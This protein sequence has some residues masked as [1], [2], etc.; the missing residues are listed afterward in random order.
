MDDFGEYDDYEWDDWEETN[1]D[2]D[3]LHETG[4]EDLDRQDDE[5][6]M[7]DFKRNNEDDT[8]TKRKR[9]TNLLYTTGSSVQLKSEHMKKLFTENYNLNPNDGPNSRNLFSRLDVVDKYWLTFDNVKVA[10]IDRNGNY[11]LSK[12]T[13][14]VQ[15]LK[16]FRTAFEMAT[17]EHRKTLNSITEEETGGGDN[18]DAISNDVRDEIHRE[19]I[20]D[21]I[22]FHDRVLQLHRDGKFTEQETR[23][24]VGITRP[25]GKPEER[26]KYLKIEREKIKQDYKDESDPERKDIFREA[27]EIIEQNIDDAKLEMYE[28]PESEEGI[29]RVREKFGEDTRTKFEKFT[30]WARENLGVLSAIAISI[31][32]IITTVVVAGK[33]TLVDAAKGVGAVG[34]ALAK[35]AK[36]AL[37]VLVPILNMLATILKWGAQGLEFL[38]K[39]LWLVAILIA[40]FIYDYYKKK[41]ENFLFHLSMK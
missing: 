13:S 37:P 33:K 14:N 11:F 18:T 38:A 12:N 4:L 28:R 16:D 32:G 39:N 30:V 29:H 15:G 31:A 40:T 17:E 5:L 20:D 19:N 7:T 8:S 41:K 2:N 1:L 9:E 6:W 24:L 22:E 26:I 35:V 25:K 23:K 21:N 36:A 10:F 34:K 27:L 3:D